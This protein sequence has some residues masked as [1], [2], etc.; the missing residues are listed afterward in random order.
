MWHHTY[1]HGPLTRY[2]KLRV[3]HA[4]RMPGTF[5]PAARPQ[6]KPLV[7]DP[8]MH[9]GTCVTHVLWCMSGSLTYGENVPGIPGACAPSILRI[10]QEAHGVTWHTGMICIELCKVRWWMKPSLLLSSISFGKYVHCVS[11][12]YVWR[13]VALWC[14][15]VLSSNPTP[16]HCGMPA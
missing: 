9:H 2:V 16:C 15:S 12:A 8:G 3:V 6:R 10:W 4:P 13:C 11:H 5:S 7:S 14:G 1:T